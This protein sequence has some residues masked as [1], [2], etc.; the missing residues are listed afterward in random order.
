MN[1]KTSTENDDIIPKYEVIF[2]RFTAYYC[3]ITFKFNLPATFSM[4][5]TVNC[6]LGNI[7]A[8][9]FFLASV[10]GSLNL[11][12]AGEKNRFHLIYTWS[13]V[14]AGAVHK[15]FFSNDWLRQRLWKDCE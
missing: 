9:I 13:Q 10:I 15:L 1:T 4:N 3:R 11:P 5:A 6:S 14:E 12:I 2:N 7:L 8:D